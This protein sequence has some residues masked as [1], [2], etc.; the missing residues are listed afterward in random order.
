MTA[1][2]RIPFARVFALA[3]LAALSISPAAFAE[4]PAV[5][6]NIVTSMIRSMADGKAEG[7]KEVR[8]PAAAEAPPPFILN[9]V[10]PEEPSPA[11]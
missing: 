6:E 10:A 3:L 9:R 1:S 8:Q 7:E 4:D 2:S 11:K 5:P